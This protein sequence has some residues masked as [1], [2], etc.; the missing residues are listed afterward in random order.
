M[1]ASII[2][3][4]LRPRFLLLR[5]RRLQTLLHLLDNLV[6]A[7]ALG[8]LTW[9]IVLERRQELPDHG[10]NY[11]EHRNDQRAKADMNRPPAD[12]IECRSSKPAG[13]SLPASL[14]R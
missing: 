2:V 5:L 3:R 1:D 7:E 13:R 9:R 10:L 12:L 4:V 14:D 8:T 6:D 11:D